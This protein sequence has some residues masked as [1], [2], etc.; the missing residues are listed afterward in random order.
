[1]TVRSRKKKRK[2]LRRRIR[3]LNDSI[4]RLWK[5]Y[6]RRAGVC[7]DGGAGR[8]RRRIEIREHRCAERMSRYYDLGAGFDHRAMLAAFAHADELLAKHGG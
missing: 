6:H 4:S 1:M 7:D 3:D 8:I 2:R 5:Q